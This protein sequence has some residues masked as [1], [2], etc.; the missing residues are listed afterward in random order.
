MRI[1]IPMPTFR[2]N[3][4]NYY[5]QRS[6]NDQQRDILT[7]MLLSLSFLYKSECFWGLECFFRQVISRC[8]LENTVLSFVIRQSRNSRQLTNPLIISQHTPCIPPQVRRARFR[9]TA[10]HPSFPQT[11]SCRQWCQRQNGG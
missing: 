9:H 7:F 6:V 2:L 11:R 5:L 4:V 10:H 1:K 8:I 3:L